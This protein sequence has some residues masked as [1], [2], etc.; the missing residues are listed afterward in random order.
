VSTCVL[1]KFYNWIGKFWKFLKG[2]IDVEHATTLAVAFSEA[3]LAQDIFFV[4]FA[5]CLQ[6]MSNQ[7]MPA[8]GTPAATASAAAAAA[9]APAGAGGSAQPGDDSKFV[10]NGKMQCTYCIEKDKKFPKTNHPVSD[11]HTLKKEIA[12]KKNGGGKGGK[13]GKGRG[14]GRS[15]RRGGK[16][17]HDKGKWSHAEDWNFGPPTLVYGKGDWGGIMRN[18]LNLHGKFQPMLAKYR[19]WIRELPAKMQTKYSRGKKSNAK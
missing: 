16:G 9:A 10:I 19:P 1:P 18:F 14:G 2:S 4:T 11:C 12:K 15:G 17:K 6:N 13:G 3:Q 5:I 8:A 7:P